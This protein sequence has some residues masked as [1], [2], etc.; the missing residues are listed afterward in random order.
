MLKSIHGIEAAGVL[1]LKTQSP[2][3]LR[4]RLR[5]EVGH[6]RRS[7]TTIGL[8]IPLGLM[9]PAAAGPLPERGSVFLRLTPMGSCR[10]RLK[11]LQRFRLRPIIPLA[12]SDK[13]RLT[14]FA[15]FANFCSIIPSLRPLWPCCVIILFGRQPVKTRRYYL[16]PWPI[17]APRRL[18][19]SKRLGPPPRHPV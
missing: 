6:T 4:W 8:N 16:L 9:D 17:F 14:H 3:T 18:T 15:T 12:T 2:S 13:S 5:V 1:S 19:V 11:S 7:E 10:T